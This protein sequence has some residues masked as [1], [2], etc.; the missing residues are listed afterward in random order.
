MSHQVIDTTQA[1]EQAI[2]VLILGVGLGSEYFIRELLDYTVPMVI[3][4]K[5]P[6]LSPELLQ[7]GKKSGLLTV[8]PKDFAQLNV[9]EEVIEQYHITHTL[10]LPVGRA[11]T[12]L[13]YINECHSFLGPKLTVTDTCTNKVKFHQ[14]LQKHHLNNPRYLVLPARS[15]DSDI[16]V[17]TTA[18]AATTTTTTDN[19]ALSENEI[20]MAAE[21][22]GF[23]LI[24]KPAFGSG[25]MGVYYCHN[26]AQ[27]RQYVVPTRF[28][29][30][31]LL[32]EEAIAGK[33]YLVNL[34]IDTE[35]ELHLVGLYD[36][37]LTPPPYRQ[38]I[39]YYAA[40]YS[41]VYK[42]IYPY[43]KALIAAFGENI[44]TSFFQCDLI[45]SP[46]GQAYAIDVSPRLTGNAIVLLEQFC[47]Y[48]PIKLYVDYVLKGKPLPAADFFPVP[49]QAAVLRFFNFAQEGT[50]TA[51]KSLL[52][53]S[54]QKHIAKL[55]NNLKIGDSVGPI[56]NG[57]AL[58]RGVILVSHP[59]L[60]TADE[61]SLRYLQGFA[62]T[63]T[64]SFA[65]QPLSTT[66]SLWRTL[67]NHTVKGGVGTA[68]TC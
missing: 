2:K 67:T 51:I 46:D 57:G 41:E 16:D 68:T 22:L 12:L 60:A 37:E 9:I 23:P 64:D 27:M 19:H 39:A 1:K 21:Q 58:Q 36:K 47:G 29:K 34:F 66:H 50:I 65:A 17:N 25:S 43:L 11:I 61:I 40:D 5:D 62:I 18:T 38:E 28:A 4:D 32:V 30:Q 24:I 20:A 26:Q 49:P 14:F 7:A 45:L 63:D 15:I 10:A 52:S 6:Q 3:M 59:D 56:S 31:P 44:H 8:I 33:E 54:E 55:E 48:S 42:Q 35:G 13:G 53:N